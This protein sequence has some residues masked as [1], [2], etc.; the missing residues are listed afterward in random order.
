M[1]SASDD[2]TARLW[3]L[4]PAQAVHRICDSTAHTL[5]PQLWQRYLRTRPSPHPA[6]ENAQCAV[7]AVVHHLV[8]AFG[9][10]AREETHM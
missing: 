5:T 8:R 7:P 1:A 2:H 9:H 6:G 3:T 4:D 10:L